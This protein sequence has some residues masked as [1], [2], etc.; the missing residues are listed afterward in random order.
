MSGNKNESVAR[1]SSAIDNNVMPGKN[2]VE[3][4]EDLKTESR[5]G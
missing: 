1:V 4:E 5:V 2:A 3:V